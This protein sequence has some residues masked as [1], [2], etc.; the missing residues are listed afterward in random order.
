MPTFLQ[1]LGL[2]FALGTAAGSALAAFFA[3]GKCCAYVGRIVRL[4]YDSKVMK[5]MGLEEFDESGD[6][7]QQQAIYQPQNWRNPK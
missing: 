2:G 5:K 3:V 6:I 4:K 1:M 7:A